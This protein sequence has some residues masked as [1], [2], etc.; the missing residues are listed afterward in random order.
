MVGMKRDVE[1]EYLAVSQKLSWGVC[2][3]DV[4]HKLPAA[5]FQRVLQKYKFHLKIG[6]TAT[7]IEKTTK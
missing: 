4:V 2:I 5:T 3:A 1:N 7:P 6:L